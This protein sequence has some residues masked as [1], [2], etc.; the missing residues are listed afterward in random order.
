MIGK[1][2]YLIM[3]HNECA[4]LNKLLKCIDDERN[5]IFLHI[6]KKADFSIEEVFK[7]Q[8]SMF[9]LIRRMNVQWGGDSQIKCEIAL[10]HEA[11][12]NGTYD[13]YHLLSGVDLPVKSQD[14]IHSFFRNNQGKN[15]IRIDPVM[16]EK[17]D[18]EERV[19]YYHF[20]QNIIGR[21][22]G[23]FIGLLWRIDNMSLYIQRISKINRLKKCPKKIYKGTNWF[24]ITHEMAIEI[25]NQEKFIKKY[26]YKS[27]CADEIF[28]QTVAMNSVLNTTVVDED[29]RCIDWMRGNP[30]IWRT[31]DIDYLLMQQHKLFARKFSDCVD[32]KVSD[33]IVN[34]I[35]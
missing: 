22:K 4:L 5:D 8:S 33:I 20:F 19:K 24:S 32:K 18:G 1:H 28:V 29:L 14:E 27:L 26:C 35:I 12:K 7:P 16:Q 31:E 15:Y 9:H 34:R 21:R 23:Y 25:V 6:D 13:Y 11:M 10:L 3:A 30:Y 2:A 17:G